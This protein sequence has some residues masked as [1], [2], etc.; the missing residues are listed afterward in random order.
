[1]EV[2]IIERTTL[3]VA[4]AII[5]L[6]TILIYH[7]NYVILLLYLLIISIQERLCYTFIEKLL[8]W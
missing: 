1:M 7:F 4:C 8:N 5:L 6:I 3:K 2:K